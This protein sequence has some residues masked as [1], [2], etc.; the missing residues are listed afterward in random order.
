MSARAAEFDA[1]YRA[2]PDPWRME[3]SRYEAAKY[4]ATLRALPR[5]EYRV[6]LEVGCSIGVL[7]ARL[8]E[9]CEALAA[10]DVSANALAR[11]RQ[12]PGCEGVRFM[13]AEVPG[14]WPA[15]PRDLIVL[16]EVLYFLEPDEIAAVAALA[17]RDLA[18]DG[19]I[20]TVNWLGECDRTIDGA[21]AAALFS[22]EARSLGLR[23]AGSVVEPSYR[24]DVLER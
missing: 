13:R 23:R 22:R 2:D 9:R 12:R 1:L 19:T 16:S 8:A 3:T 18:P 21:G 17:V 4:D 11:A 14:D 15:A 7:T 6:G 20:I 10:L 24:I 5:A